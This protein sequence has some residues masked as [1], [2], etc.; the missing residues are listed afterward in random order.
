MKQNYIIGDNILTI[1]CDDKKIYK[2]IN[3][4]LIIFKIVDIEQEN[5]LLIIRLYI[6]LS[7]HIIVKILSPII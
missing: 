5:N 7:S 2:R 6:F 4:W 1:I 3:K